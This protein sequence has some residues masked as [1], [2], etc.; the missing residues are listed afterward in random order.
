MYLKVKTIFKCFFNSGSI[1]SEDIKH[2]TKYEEDL[3]CNVTAQSA[4]TD[5]WL[6]VAV[7]IMTGEADVIRHGDRD[8]EGR[9]QNQ[10]IP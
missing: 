2:Y 10:P 6:T 9:Q 8:I 3:H 5:K 4:A 7:L 1:Q